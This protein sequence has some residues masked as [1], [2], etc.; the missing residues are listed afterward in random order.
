VDYV[1]I[2]GGNARRLKELPEGCRLGSN[3]LALPGGERL[4]S[5]EPTAPARPGARAAP[6][7]A[8]RRRRP[9]AGER[10]AA[11]GRR[12]GLPAPKP[13]VASQ[14]AAGDGAATP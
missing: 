10:G 1:V 11:S 2:G 4:W 9:A 14:E 13:G 8:A 3:A 5:V 6:A 12:S 7:R